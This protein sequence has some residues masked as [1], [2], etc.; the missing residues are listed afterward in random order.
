LPNADHD[1]PNPTQV[2]QGEDKELGEIAR[3]IEA[4]FARAEHQEIAAVEPVLTPD[5]D[6]DTPDPIDSA[7]A[8]P[9]PQPDVDAPDPILWSEPAADA[10]EADSPSESEV[11]GPDPVVPSE[12]EVE[13]ADPVLAPDPD[14]ETPEPF[15]S[16]EEESEAPELPMLSAEEPD[17]RDEDIPADSEPEQAVSGETH[18]E[19]GPPLGDV[20]QAL[21]EVTANYLRVSRGEK[22]AR[23]FVWRSRLHIRHVPWT[24]SHPTSTSCFSKLPGMRRSRIWRTS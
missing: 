18:T 24:R 20:E 21:S 1:L 12:P 2:T 14:P 3:S 23:P 9:A 8:V 22:R 17:G 19:S 4:I 7:D 5:P 11:D 13:A 6:V 10:I 15:V 16:S